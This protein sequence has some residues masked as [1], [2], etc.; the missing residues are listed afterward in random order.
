MSK[1]FGNRG[2]LAAFFAA[3]IATSL[4]VK[5]GGGYFLLGYGP[6]ANQT[7]GT[8]TAMG[9]DAFSGANNPAKLTEV[10]DKF[11]LS[12]IIFSPHRTIKR[13]GSGTPFDFESE[14]ENELFILPAGGIAQ[15][16]NDR[17]SW[18]V[19]LYGNGGLNTEYRDDTGIPGTNANPARCGDQPGNFFFGCGK[20]GF[21]LA[22][23]IVAPTLAFKLTD[24]H[25]FGIA[26]L[27]GYQRFKAYGLQAF[28]AIS[29]TPQAVSNNGKDDAYG[30]G[31]RVGWYGKLTPWL[32]AG[33]AYS[34]KIY[35]QK[36]DKYRG[37]LAD[38]GRFD[39]PENYN[40]GIAFTGLNRWVVGLDVQ[41]IRFGD[42]RALGNAASNSLDDPANRPLGSRDGSGFNWATQTIYKIAVA[43]QFTPEITLRTGYAYGK[44]AQRDDSRDSVSL[45]LLAPNPVH[46]AS[47]G[48]SW[49]FS[50]KNEFNLGW[51]RYFRGTYDGPSASD[52]IGVGGTESITPYVNQVHLTWTRSL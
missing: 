12:A 26:P 37:L 50:E 28:E 4:P 8:V 3:A 2:C 22:Q 18:G 5:A 31:V 44:R 41:R 35:M 33:A 1:L 13:E 42:I 19:T 9:F 15:K 43:H 17:W 39:I 6:Y 23:I 24:K 49:Q 20:L 21:D 30:I 47:V 7:A 11:D 48:M 29:Q 16:I 27:L 40:V 25:S 51:S 52:A 10:S 34:S 38:G 46:Q 45:N 14:S 36:F 32:N